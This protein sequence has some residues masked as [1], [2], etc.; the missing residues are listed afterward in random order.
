MTTD[1]CG[2]PWWRAFAHFDPASSCWRTSQ[3]TFHSAWGTFSETWPRWGMT[4]GGDAFALPTPGHLTSGTDCSSLLPT[5]NASDGNGHGTHGDGSPDLRTTVALLPTPTA[6]D[7][8]G[9]RGHRPD[10]TPYTA[11]SGVTLTDAAMASAGAH[12]APQSPGGKPSQDDQL[13]GQLN[14]LDG[15][16]SCA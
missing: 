1:T 8:H 2:P 16:E 3:G 9:S 12:T 4:R 7:A 10:G 13:P 11:T 5:P 15:L 14:L 6:M